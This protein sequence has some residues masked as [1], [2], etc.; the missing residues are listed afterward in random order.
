MVFKKGASALASMI[1]LGTIIVLVTG[2]TMWIEN[3]R[4]ANYTSNTNSNQVL[5]ATDSG[6]QD[7]LSRLNLQPSVT[8]YSTIMDGITV[9]VCYY[10][11]TPNTGVYTI[12][13]KAIKGGIT[14]SLKA[15]ASRDADTLKFKIYSQE[16]EI[17]TPCVVQEMTVP[18]A[19]QN[20][21]WAGS[22]SGGVNLT[23]SAPMGADSA[24]IS[25][26]KVYR[27]VTSGGETLLTTLGNTLSYSDTGLTDNANY[28]YKVS[29][30]NA[31]GEGPLSGETLAIPGQPPTAG[32]VTVSN[33]AY[34]NYVGATYQIST[35]FT[36]SNT[37][38]SCDY[39][40][41]GGTTWSGAT[42]SGALP[43]YTCSKTGVTALDNISYSINMR[44]T[45]S[46]GANSASAITKTGDATGPTVVDN[47]DD[48]NWTINSPVTITLAPTDSG[49]GVSTTKYCTDTNNSCN[50]SAGTT[51][52]STSF[53]CS[54]SSNCTNYIRYAAWDNVNNASQI[55]YKRVR[56]DK[57]VPTDG[58]LTV[59]PGNYQNS[60]S[61]SGFSDTGSGLAAANTYKVVFLTTGAPNAACSNGTQVYLGSG[62][63]TIHTSLTGGTTYYYRVC[64]YDTVG[65]I[66]NGA[67][68]NGVPTTTTT[69]T[70]QPTC[71]CGSWSACSGC[72]YSTTCATSATGT[73]TRTCSPSGCLSESQS[74]TCTRST[75]GVSCGSCTG[76]Y[77][78]GT[79]DTTCEGNQN[80]CSG[81]T[82]SST[83]SC[84]CG[85]RSTSGTTCGTPTYSNCGG[86]VLNGGCTGEKVCDYTT[87][88]CN[89]SGSCVSA[90]DPG[91]G[92]QSCTAS[93]G[94]GCG[95]TYSSW[96]GC[97]GDGSCGAYPWRQ[98]RTIYNWHCSSGSCVQDG[99]CTNCDSRC[100]T[101]V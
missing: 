59:T 19:P 1:A 70:T 89:G 74:C 65:N 41:N 40:T 10:P 33:Y 4:L 66:S 86:C 84:S 93:N 29:A 23:W 8:D 94:T 43:N 47:W 87:Y 100:C 11:D 42:L 96:S 95:T 73:Q 51:G 58:T 56:Q 38:I 13:T 83:I 46:I 97:S 101:P 34:G 5:V 7:A 64:A 71:S 61:W 25:N 91:G 21:V 78:G 20:L 55:Y 67:T 80:V 17:D 26:Y 82:C 22:T 27:G 3:S 57:L 99:T 2:T 52:V 77:T 44:L 79:C 68:G 53:T 60:L 9:G 12:R 88:S 36:S 69:S 92:I 62:T 31:I 6:L 98:Y 90:T 15:L 81:G 63:S 28:Y 30:V 54:A 72:S 32:A 49:A 75:D 45:N 39:S 85:T 18:N 50:P 48:S 37:A 24:S 76:S 35:P 14:R 16:E